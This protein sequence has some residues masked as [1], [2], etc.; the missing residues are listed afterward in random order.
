LVLI[1]DG[2]KLSYGDPEPWK[3]LVPVY[4][5]THP[6]RKLKAIQSARNDGRAP[7]TTTKLVPVTKHNQMPKSLQSFQYLRNELHPD[8]LRLFTD[9][10]FQSYPWNGKSSCWFDTGMEAIFFCFLHCPDQMRSILEQYGT[11]CLDFSFILSHITTRL[12][13]Y[14]STQLIPELQEQLFGLRNQLALELGLNL[15]QDSNPVVYS[16]LE[17][18]IM[19]NRLGSHS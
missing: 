12:E 10:A 15:F 17:I 11:I 4:G 5:T 2:N 7:D 14:K 3:K 16:N 6:S 13:I 9:W 8:G 18:L 1:L 19:Y